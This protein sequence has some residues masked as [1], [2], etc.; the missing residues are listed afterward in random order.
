MLRGNSL[1]WDTREGAAE[2]R[3]L[4]HDAIRLDPGYALAHALLAALRLNGWFEDQGDSA[5]LLDEAERHAR[6]AVALDE[7]DSACFSMLAWVFQLRRQFDLALQH[8]ERAA[9][10]NANNP[11][12]CADMG[13][14]LISHGDL[15]AAL[16]WL[17]RAREIDPFFDVSWYWRLV[18]QAHILQGRYRDALIALDRVTV[19][20]F[21][22]SALAAAC[23]G[24]LGD[25]ARAQACVR[26]C[27]RLKP[28][29][30]VEAYMR[31]A[32]F[33]LDEHADRQ[34]ALFLAAGLP[35]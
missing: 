22:V 8:Q 17:A 28:D 18:G 10:L 31:K 5:E 35:A 1:A 23:H 25:T 27:L 20:T 26:D 13:G 6:L 4:F 24:A 3:R 16:G 12:N 33:R 2:A 30:S 29:F 32:P 34:R 19:P 15:D 11:W 21:R 9:A 14:T 7:N